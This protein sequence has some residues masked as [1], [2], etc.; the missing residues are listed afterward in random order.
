MNVIKRRGSIEPVSFDKIYNRVRY[1]TS[2]PSP[3]NDVNTAELTQLVIIGL[4]DNIKTTEID[5]YSAELAASFGIKNLQ[6]MVLA[7]R[8]SINNHQKNTLNGFS[9]KI[10]KLYL[11]VDKNNKASP[12]IADAFYKY[13][14]RNKSKI[15]KYIKYDRDYLYDYF[16][17]ETLKNGY[18]LTIDGVIVERPQDLIMRVAIQLH[19]PMIQSDFDDVSYLE[20]IFAVYDRISMRYY[21]PATPTLFNSGS[22]TA[23][24][25]SC[26]LL[27]SDDSLDGIMKTF[28]KSCT[29]S[30]GSGGIGMHVSMWRAEGSYIRGTNGES[31]GII[32]QLRIF[33]AGSRAYDQGGGKRKGSWAVY[34]EPHHPDIMNFLK[35]KNTD[36][37]DEETKC[38]D[39]FPAMWL[40]DLFME[41]VRD[42]A[43]WSVFC[44]D[45]CPGLQDVFGDEYKE[46]YHKYEGEGRAKFT[47]PALDIWMAIHKMQENSGTP[48]VMYKDNV[49]RVNMQNNIGTI[50]S[51]NL[52]VSGDT[53]ILTDNGQ[54]AIKDLTECDPPVHNV[55]N[56]D[57]FT[58]AT[59]AKTGVDQELLEIETTHGATIKCT[60][61]HKFIII[62]PY[63]TERIVEAHMLRVGYSLIETGLPNEFLD[64]NKIK[65]I[66][67][68]V[69]KEDTYCFNEPI[70]N[71]GIFNGMLLGNC[72]E[73]VEYSSNNEYASCNLHSICLPRFVT[74]SYSQ[75]EL[76]INES[77]RRPLNN[78][79]PTH[80]VMNYKLLA[81]IASEVTENLNNVIDRVHNPVLEAA[82][83]N[84]RNRPI[85]IGVQGLADVFLMFSLPFDSDGAR[86][87]NK[88]IS[89]AI[90]YGAMSKSTELCRTIYNK[91]I[92]NFEES[93]EQVLYPDHVLE[94]YPL[95]M[96]ENKLETYNN[97]KDIPKT[98][99]AYPT[100]L[101]NG[102]SH[103]SHGKFHW[104]LYGLESKDLS[105]LF[106]W[107][108]LRSHIA[109]YGV[110][111]SLVAAYMPTGTTSQ[112]MG[113][114][115]C[116]EPYTNNMYKTNTLA[117]T[118]TIIN[119]Y[120]VKYLQDSGLYTKEFNDYLLR[121]KGSIK[122]VVG[123]PDNIKALFRTARELKQSSL[124]NLAIDRQPFIDQSQSMNLWFDNYTLDKFTSSQFYAWKNGLKTGSYYIRTKAAFD[125]Q[126]FTISPHIQNELNL[127]EIHKMEKNNEHVADADDAEDI[128][129]M[130]SS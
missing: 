91:I 22:P 106:D 54:F 6:Y 99:G 56:G 76:L 100:Y 115:P 27:G 31:R 58:P 123:I 13:V 75:E 44:P 10:T 81:T 112:I 104:E 78:E 32:P 98:I 127:L 74:D 17:F 77:D 69:V 12:I 59:F 94:K 55:W 15:D 72:T 19:M 48:Y 45:E 66:K 117:G 101:S 105:G 18:L 42:N 11:H 97:K 70:K 65:S 57:K 67:T 87:L 114:S 121:V 71:R 89:E 107:E 86:V 24:L 85:G 73:I 2:N 116:I 16:G 30:K 38:R 108:T 8:I 41:R 129:L 128:C 62:G 49:N 37:K 103:M 96:D 113:C 20:K 83:G 46:L 21:T 82:R 1:L 63:N 61:Y 130:C 53:L 124:M 88:R 102:G 111:N 110:R 14:N 36:G 43:E 23:S 95:L 92:K 68:L 93:Y 60:A 120:F 5:D 126:N 80:P 9:D 26:F 118:F 4:K 119:K 47:I 52:C 122:D 3:L 33:N 64:P 35:L 7:S 79:F 40:S 84:F 28:A 125:P 29:I 109:I 25:S 51:S 34:L 39:L 90:Y 50:K